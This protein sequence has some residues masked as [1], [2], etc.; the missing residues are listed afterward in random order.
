MD[1][2]SNIVAFLGLADII[3]RAGS[4]LYDFIAAIKDAP[5]EIRDLQQDLNGVN[6]LLNELKE[7]WSGLSVVQPRSC[8]NPLIDSCVSSLRIIYRD[9]DVLLTTT[10]KPDSSKRI[11]S[12]WVKI[13][14]VFEDK[15]VAKLIRSL[16]RHKLFLVTAVALDG[17]YNR[18]TGCP[19][20][21]L[22]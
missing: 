2:A 3:L 21:L 7:H 22:C 5:Q 13:K 8:L 11:A 4:K 10:R 14:W 20:D 19:D 1:G 15:Q 9:L 16:K 17:K 18:Q 12:T 6:L